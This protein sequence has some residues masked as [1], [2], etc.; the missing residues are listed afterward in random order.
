MRH[1]ESKLQQTCVRWFRL[2]YPQ[3]S[4]L[5]FAVPNGGYR[6]ALEAKIMQSE[7]V[8]AGVSDLILM[9]PNARYCALCIEIKYGKGKQT[10]AQKKWQKAVTEQGYQYVVINNFD[11]FKLAIEIYFAE[12]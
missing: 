11:D 6:R 9:I 10:D 12:M 2:Q 4:L 7:G 1:L 5:L 8:I 3:Y